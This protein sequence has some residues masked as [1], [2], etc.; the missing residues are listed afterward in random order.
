VPQNEATIHGLR[1]LCLSS[2]GMSPL[3]QRTPLRASSLNHQLFS[4][5]RLFS[6]ISVRELFLFYGIRTA[7]VGHDE[8]AY[9]ALGRNLVFMNTG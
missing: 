6:T 8:I 3:C 9:G 2:F 7:F 5:L 4:M 1:L